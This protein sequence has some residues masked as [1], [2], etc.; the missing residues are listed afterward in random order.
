LWGTPAIPNFKIA[1]NAP[2]DNQGIGPLFRGTAEAMGRLL[3]SHLK[4]AKIEL[5]EDTSAMAHR[6]GFAVAFGLLAAIGYALI[7][8]AIVT[9]IETFIGRTFA[10]LIIGAPHLIGGVLGTVLALRPSKS[11]EFLPQTSRDVAAS[12]EALQAPGRDAVSGAERAF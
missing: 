11:A 12:F 9:W 1:M 10:L 8:L 4:L 7:L 5:E 3:G 2:T 6:A